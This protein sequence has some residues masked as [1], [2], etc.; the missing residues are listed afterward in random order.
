MQ[1]KQRPTA[2]NAKLTFGVRRTELNTVPLHPGTDT[3][4]LGA[5]VDCESSILD[6]ARTKQ[7]HSQPL[8]YPHSTPPLPHSTL[9]AVEVKW[10]RGISL[11]W[12][13]GTLTCWAGCQIVQLCWVGLGLTLDGGG[14]LRVGG[15]GCRIRCAHTGS[16]SAAAVRTRCT[17]VRCS[18]KSRNVSNWFESKIILNFLQY[19]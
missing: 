11:R 10:L 5:R 19:S 6:A 16:S 18:W 8:I 7:A 2:K 4:E 17:V 15:E 14:L 9:T 12:T 3:P 1:Q 13:P